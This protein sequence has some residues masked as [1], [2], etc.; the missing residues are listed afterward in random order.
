MA[1]K[2]A[3]KKAKKAA[4]K[5]LA[6]LSPAGRTAAR[7]SAARKKARGAAA[8]SRDAAPTRRAATVPASADDDA[9]THVWL[10]TK[11]GVHQLD[12][13]RA[14][15]QR[16]AL[17]WAY[18]VRNR[19]RWAGAARATEK[20]R[21][22]ARADLATLGVTDALL[23]DFARLGLVEVGTGWQ[24]EDLGWEARV[25]PW[26]YLLSGATKH[27]RGERPLTVV[28]H[29]ETGA[30]RHAPPETMLFVESTPGRLDELFTFEHEHAMLDL[31]LGLEH[32]PIRS[33]PT[34]GEL[35]EV[36]EQHD[37]DVVH[38][39]GVDSHQGA[40]LLGLEVREEPFDGLYLRGDDDRE[41]AVPAEEVAATIATGRKKPALFAC[42][43]YHSAPRTCALAVA[44]GVGT[45]LGFYGMID[46]DVAERFFATFYQAWK[47]T[48][49]DTLAAFDAAWKDVRDLPRTLRGSGF[50][51][52]S[53]SSL[54][55]AAGMPRARLRGRKGAPSKAPKSAEDAR[56]RIAEQRREVIEVH[57]PIQE[58]LTVEV[59]PKQRLNYAQ[60]HNGDGLFDDFTFRKTRHGLLRGVGVTVKLYVG[61][62]EFPYTTTLD[63]DRS[64]RALH[65]EIRVPLTWEY[66]RG[67]EES[68]RTTLYWKVTHGGATV[69]EDTRPITL[70]P[71]EEWE[72]GRRE[73]ELWLPSFV[74]PRDPGVLRIVDRARHYVRALTDDPA[75]GFAGY[76]V[77]EEGADDPSEGVDLQVR[78]IWS[79][80]LHDFDLVY[81]NPPPSY[82]DTTQR[83]R[84]PSEVL[85]S[86]S[87]TCIDLSLL[88]ASCLEYVEIYPVIF[89]LEGHAFPGYWRSEAD[90]EHFIEADHLFEAV[91]EKRGSG[92]ATDARWSVGKRAWREVMKLIE[93]DRLV[94]LE[95]V[96]LTAHEG[97]ARAFE[98]GL[99]NLADSKQ[100]ERL[101]DVTLARRSSITPLPL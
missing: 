39:T 98:L 97:F 31:N 8:A 17:G 84:S 77:V 54:V 9:T 100:F 44:H 41:H 57:E 37:P 56:A 92:D 72:Y 43:A 16:L 15:L 66:V 51:L 62:D 88:V 76:Q 91:D 27:H 38:F 21:E 55:E 82:S 95:S 89:L 24:R 35:R 53:A 36:V 70:L 46:D 47:L 58:L 74:L 48:G 81:I 26:E 32:V 40:E 28:R 68:V 13:P 50:V 30:A 23:E 20:I 85:D 52:W 71:V 69:R 5:K 75:A 90:H 7:A 12:C 93:E 4:R 25:M 86:G 101:I 96:S 42:N 10:R 99:D 14:T 60:L 6:R 87:G 33:N 59:E 29:L 63:F 45:A 49:F 22:R 3:R 67:L 79:A 94:P 64:P 19:Q 2:K 65:G 11:D 34:L 83:L 73:D 18:T 78:A 1:S 61:S 80:L